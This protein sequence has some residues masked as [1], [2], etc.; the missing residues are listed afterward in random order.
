MKFFHGIVK[1]IVSI[2]LALCAGLIVIIFLSS[3][4][5]INAYL[6]RLI[7]LAAIG[8]IGGLGARILFRGIPSILTFLLSTLASLIAVLSIDHFYETAYQ[9]QFLDSNFRVYTPSASDGSQLI[10]IILV[11]LFPLLL[12]KRISKLT[13]KTQKSQAAKKVHKP[14]SI[15]LQPF[16]AK[17]N[18][19]NWKLWKKPK[20]KK[21]T[22]VR[23]AWVEKPILAVARPNLAK[24]AA[25]P[26]TIHKKV[27]EKPAAKK[28]KL[29]GK[30]FKGNQADVKLVGEEEHVC[31]YC[32]EEVVKGD[33]RGVT[34]CPECGTW[35]HQDC[36]S[37]T[38]SCGVAHRNE[39]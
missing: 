36:W 4:P 30:F 33:M 39:L 9:L 15:S 23:T 28:L 21:R 32:L 12:F 16:L 35:H 5:E 3:K 29:P 7:I 20:V 1:W 31:P 34:I 17:A 10:L 25:L 22:P 6:L 18:P 37:L 24:S 13:K 11:S 2:A 19:A 27:A 26:V 38:G 14:F 8:F